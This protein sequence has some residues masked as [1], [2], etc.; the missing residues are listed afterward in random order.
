M[1][2]YTVSVIDSTI[3]RSRNA[4]LFVQH[5]ATVAASTVEAARNVVRENAVHP[6]DRITA[7]E[8]DGLSVYT[9]SR[10]YFPAQLAMIV[11][12]LDAEFL[13]SDFLKDA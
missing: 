1:K 11:T 10:R 12:P 7:R 5:Y 13:G 8:A 2:L 9:G 3:P 4:K 6:N